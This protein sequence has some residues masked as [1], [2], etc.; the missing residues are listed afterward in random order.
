MNLDWFIDFDGGSGGLISRKRIHTNFLQQNYTQKQ[1]SIG[2]GNVSG[3]SE[4][5]NYLSRHYDHN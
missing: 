3:C 1:R 2:D 5:L 4:E